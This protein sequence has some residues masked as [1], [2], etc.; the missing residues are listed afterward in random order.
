LAKRRSNYI[1]YADFTN[2]LGIT[3]VDYLQARQFE[4]SIRFGIREQ[5]KDLIA[6]NAQLAKANIQVAK[7]TKESIDRGFT[8]LSR[9]LGS[10]RD[11]IRDGIQE[12]NA[13]FEWGFSERE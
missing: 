9:D 4:D 13:T 12:L 11:T 1:G 6:S 8:V 10:L 3:Y 7:Q 5:T 2:Q